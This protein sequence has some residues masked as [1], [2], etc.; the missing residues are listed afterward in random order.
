MRQF[1]AFVSFQNTH[2]DQADHSIDGFPGVG[3]PRPA[4]SLLRTTVGARQVVD[5][6]AQQTF[7][8]SV[9]ST[10]PAPAPPETKA[11]RPKA[12]ARSQRWWRR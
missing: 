3:D 8:F 2:A 9:S 4:E 7:A 5:A 11:L 10:E 12:A 1:F 6:A